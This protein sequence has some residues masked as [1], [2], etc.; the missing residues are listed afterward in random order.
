MAAHAEVRPFAAGHRHGVLEIAERLAALQRG[1]V[2]APLGGIG[3]DFRDIPAVLADQRLR[4]DADTGE[5]AAMQAG[6]AQA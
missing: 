6:E 2:R 3:V 5:Y 1:A 4:V